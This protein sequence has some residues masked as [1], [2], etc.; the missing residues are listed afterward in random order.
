VKINKKRIFLVAGEVGRVN[1]GAILNEAVWPV[2]FEGVST[3]EV[4]RRDL[5]IEVGE[6]FCFCV[7]RGEVIELSALGR[8]ASSESDLPT[9]KKEVA[10][11]K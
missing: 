3:A 8:R 6:T 2:P 4:K 10:S 11:Y 5:M 1:Q 7:R 9:P